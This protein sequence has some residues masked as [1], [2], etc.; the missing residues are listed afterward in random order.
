MLPF[1]L[2]SGLML[3]RRATV[4]RGLWFYIPYTRYRYALNLVSYYTEVL[5]FC[6]DSGFL[7][8]RRYR[9]PWILVSDY[10]D[11]LPLFM[12]SGFILHRRATIIL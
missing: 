1:C 4:M 6:V 3:H 5:P 2:D 11:V 8:R 10:I 9:Y 12:D 7:L